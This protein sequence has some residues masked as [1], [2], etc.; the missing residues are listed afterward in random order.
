MFIWLSLKESLPH[1]DLEA[2]IHAFLTSR[3]DYCNSLYCGL[4]QTA[5]SHLQVVQNSAAR[6]LTWTK[7]RDHIF[8]ILAC[9][10][11][12]PVKF[13][14][15]FKI[16]V[17]VCKALSDLAPKYSSDLLIP[18]S[19]QRALRSNNQLLLTVPRCRCK[20]KGGR[21]FSAAAPKLWNSLPENVRLAPSLA[22]FKSVLKSYLF[23]QAFD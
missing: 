4:P 18:Y 1:K 13:R 8:P 21:A 10:L 9:L 3:L 2:V 17:F 14:I 7:K 11:W 19:P 12:L 16:A 20:T 5:I 15:Y 6:L 23:S 22:R